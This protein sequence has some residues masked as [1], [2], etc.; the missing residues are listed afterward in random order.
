MTDLDIRGFVEHVLEL[1][2]YTCGDVDADLEE[3]AI[4]HGLFDER[5]ATAEDCETDW[6]AEIQR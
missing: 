2:E 1:M 6:G 5:P 3:A 4:K